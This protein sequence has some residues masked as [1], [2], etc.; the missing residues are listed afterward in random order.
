MIKDK[1]STSQKSAPLLS[2]REELERYAR[3]SES[4][5]Q[6]IR[7]NPSAAIQFLKTIGYNGTKGKSAKKKAR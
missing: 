1:I 7:S 3:A 5:R 6:E 2:P 4:F